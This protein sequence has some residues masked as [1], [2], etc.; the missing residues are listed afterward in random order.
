MHATRSIDIPLAATAPDGTADT[1][2]VISVSCSNPSVRVGV[3]PDNPRV[4]FVD[5]L[6]PTA[7]GVNV[8]AT[9][10]E[11]GLQFTDT[12]QVTVAPAPN[13]GAV[14]FGGSPSAEYDT[15]ASR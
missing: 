2:G 11:G 5:G 3:R 7:G 1:A 15:P 9:V 6:T 14:A 10:T 8:V 4:A 13:R 12:V